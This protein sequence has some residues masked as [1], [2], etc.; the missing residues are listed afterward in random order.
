[1][2]ARFTCDDQ[3]WDQSS[4]NVGTWNVA[5]LLQAGRQEQGIISVAVTARD[6]PSRRRQESGPQEKCLGAAALKP[7][8]LST[9]PHIFLQQSSCDQPTALLLLL[10]AERCSC[11][12]ACPQLACSTAMSKLYAAHLCDGPIGLLIPGV[13]DTHPAGDSTRRAPHDCVRQAAEDH[14]Q[15]ANA[16]GPCSMDA[17]GR[18]WEST[19]GAGSSRKGAQGKWDGK[20]HAGSSC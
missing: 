19:V 18:A 1:M 4:R 12:R 17:G 14:L 10:T 13:G 3:G 16:A 2:H 9:A 5:H 6:G 20:Q 15:G 8:Q 11:P 7:H